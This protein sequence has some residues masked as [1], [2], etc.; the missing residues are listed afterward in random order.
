MLSQ[1]P[2]IAEV[3][4]VGRPDER[5][6]EVVVAVVVPKPGRHVSAERITELLE[7]QVARY[8]LP[9]DVVMM[10]S[11]PRTALGK[12]MREKIKTVVRREASVDAA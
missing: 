10:Q 2:D 11:L 4:V 6:G 1:C 3:A 12:V 5:W 8:K 7:G 9:R